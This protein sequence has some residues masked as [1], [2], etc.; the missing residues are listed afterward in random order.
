MC[1]RLV[2]ILVVTAFFAQPLLA[3]QERPIEIE[4]WESMPIQEPIPDYC[5]IHPR[6]PYCWP[7]PPNP[8]D[9]VVQAVNDG[10]K[11]CAIGVAI[12]TLGWFISGALT[13]GTGWLSWPAWGKM[14]TA[15]CIAGGI[16]EPARQQY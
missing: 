4:G 1:S 16:T 13:G 2:I 9:K 15:S 8:G 11:G 5:T 12:G 3:L 7:I 6:D 14:A 10:M